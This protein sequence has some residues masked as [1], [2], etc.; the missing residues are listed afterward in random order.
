MINKI[1]YLMT[2][3]HQKMGQGS[4]FISLKNEMRK[5]DSSFDCI[6]AS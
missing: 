1:E 2:S 3:E 5:G 6:G 4:G